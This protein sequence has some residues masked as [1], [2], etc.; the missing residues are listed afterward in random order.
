L[1]SLTI[2]QLVFWVSVSSLLLEELLDFELDSALEELS[3]SELLL[4]A[5]LLVGFRGAAT[6]WGVATFLVGVLP[7]ELLWLE[8]SRFLALLMA[9]GVLARGFLA[10]VNVGPLV[11]ELLPADALLR[12]PLPPLCCCFLGRP[13]PFF[14]VSVA[15]CV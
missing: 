14:T 3:S 15:G 12:L 4:P 5:V 8:C 1:F 2:R 9:S 11:W 6:S 10:A 7:L 13:R